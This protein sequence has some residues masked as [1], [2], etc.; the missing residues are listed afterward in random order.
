MRVLVCGG[1]DYV[2][3]KRLSEEMESIMPINLVIDGAARGADDLAHKWAREHGV[4]SCRFPAQWGFYGNRAGPIRN[5]WMLDYGKPDLVLAF[6]GG[7][8][9]ANMVGKAREVGVEVRQVK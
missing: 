4:A 2:D 3:F 6:P 8:G 1:R 9:T 7:R 5:T